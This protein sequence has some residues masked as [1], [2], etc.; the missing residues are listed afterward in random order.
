MLIVE[1]V[2]KAYQSGLLARQRTLAVNEVSFSV[3]DD[4]IFGLVGESG[5][6]KTTIGKMIV[7]LERPSSGAIH[8]G[9]TEITR[10]AG[11]KLRAHWSRLQMIFQDPRS[12]LNPRMRVGESLVEGLKLAGQTQN[13]QQAAKDLADR[14]SVRAEILKRYPHEVSG[15]EI[16]R[17]VI[18]RALSLNPSVLVADEPTSNLDMSVQAQVLHLLKEVQQRLRIPCVLISHDIHVVR[19]MC[20]RI[21]ILHQGM[22][23]ETG[24]A[25]S[26]ISQP[27]HPYTRQLMHADS[28]CCQR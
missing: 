5:C 14:V 3:A 25:E 13:L 28:V 19:R 26:V 1:K 24:D 6:G 2:S 9:D 15:G 18:A 7:R 4:E 17:I 8:I 16:Q 20:Q 21:A 27:Q 12:S 11:R 22:I 23:V 10:L